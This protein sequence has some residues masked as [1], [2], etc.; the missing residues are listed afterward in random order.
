MRTVFIYRLKLG[1]GSRLKVVHDCLSE[2]GRALLATS[3]L[4]DSGE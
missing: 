4:T 1:S 2:G 3:K